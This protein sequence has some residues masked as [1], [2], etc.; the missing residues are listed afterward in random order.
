MTGLK[1]VTE[2]HCVGEEPDGRTTCTCGWRA[3]QGFLF[4]E[5]S[6]GRWHLLSTGA[7]IDNPLLTTFLAP[8]TAAE[9]ADAHAGSEWMAHRLRRDRFCAEYAWAIPTE[10]IL[11]RLAEL[12]PIC[13][14][15]CGTGY[16]ASLLAKAGAE[17]LA[18]DAQPPLQGDNIWHRA[19]K[20]GIP[21][22]AA[23]IRHYV[24]VVVG[25]AATY[26]VPP[27]H[28]LML[29]WPPYDDPMAATALARY[30]GD[31][32][33]YVGESG[34]GCTADDAFHEALAEH[35]HQTTY[36]EIPQWPGLHDAV[37]VY[38]RRKR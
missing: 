25:D 10:P 4:D 27:S 12:S 31:R 36:Y 28:A 23:T 21:R 15:G 19:E 6:F 8:V 13:D 2:M 14:L 30:R 16:W 9:I 3:P 1:T 7:T 35:W 26:D 38:E 24:D 17:V 34:G 22:R 11:H 5:S 20:A 32:V 18:V 37:H 33:I 29:C